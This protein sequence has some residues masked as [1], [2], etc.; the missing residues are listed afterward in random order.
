[1]I[2]SSNWKRTILVRSSPSGIDPNRTPDGARTHA[3]DDV[4]FAPLVTSPPKILCLGLNYRAHIL[5][6]GH[7]FPDHPTVFSKFP[8][9]LIGARDDIWLP[10]ESQSV[11]WEAELGIVI[12]RRVRRASADDARAAIA[13]FTVVNDISMRDW[14]YRTPQ[15]DAGQDVGARHAGGSVDGDARRSRRCRA[16]CGSPA[17]STAS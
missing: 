10:K 17:R 7:D 5:E 15:W 14:Q 8:I 2:E 6:M 12:G 4:V 9:A 16:T 13:G 11:D 3:L 1:M